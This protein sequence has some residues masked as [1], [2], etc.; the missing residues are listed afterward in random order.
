MPFP[1]SIRLHSTDKWDIE[2]NTIEDKARLVMPESEL[3]L[4]RHFKKHGVDVGAPLSI[5]TV[6]KKTRKSKRTSDS[7]VVT[8]PTNR[9]VRGATFP[10][11]VSPSPLQN[12][13]PR[14]DKKVAQGKTKDAGD[15]VEADENEASQNQDDEEGPPEGSGDAIGT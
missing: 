3:H 11:M 15:D 13:T 7:F 4:Y 8:T 5:D 9:P 14:N 6:E 12:G 10:S 2:S 1:S